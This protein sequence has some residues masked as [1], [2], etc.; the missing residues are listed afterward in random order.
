[1]YVFNQSVAVNSYDQNGHLLRVN[2]FVSPCA[3]YVDAAT[4]AKK[5]AADPALRA[6]LVLHRADAAGHQRARHARTRR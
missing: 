6:L 4:R 2:G 3:A 5:I 1:M